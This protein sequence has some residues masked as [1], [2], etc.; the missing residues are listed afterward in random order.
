M[1]ARSFFRKRRAPGKTATR[2]ADKGSRKRSFYDGIASLNGAFARSGP[3]RSRAHRCKALAQRP[4][5][6]LCDSIEEGGKAS[7]LIWFHLY[8]MEDKGNYDQ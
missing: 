1:L 7:G 8:F 4:L 5:V 3:E 2:P 6:V